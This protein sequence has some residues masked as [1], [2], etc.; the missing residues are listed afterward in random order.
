MAVTSMMAHDGIAALEHGDRAD[1]DSLLADVRVHH[2]EDSVVQPKAQSVLVESP[3]EDHRPQQADQLAWRQRHRVARSGSGDRYRPD[4]SSG[5]G[6]RLSQ[7]GP[8]NTQSPLFV[9]IKGYQ[10]RI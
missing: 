6:A 1:S 4:P 2:A 5:D 8:V 9:R 7:R 3:H 10:S